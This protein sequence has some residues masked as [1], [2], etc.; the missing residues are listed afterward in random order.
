MSLHKSLSLMLSAI[1]SQALASGPSP[2]P[3]RASLPTTPSGPAP[4]RANL[5]ARQAQEQGLLTS[6]TSGHTSTTSLSS[7]ALLSSLESKLRQKTDLVGS[8][9]YKLTWKRRVTPAGRWIPALRGTARRTSAN[10][11][12]SQVSISDILK[13]WT[14]PPAHDTS[15][16]SKTQKAK[17][18]CACLTL[19]AQLAGWPTALTRDWKDSPG[20]APTGVNPDGSHRDR[21][22]NLS[23]KSQ[24]AG[25]GTPLSNHA[26]GSPEGFLERKRKSVERGNKMGIS[27]SDLN[28]QAQSYL[29][30]WPTA[31]QADGEKNVRT[32]E[33]SLS[34][35][36]RKGSPQDL[37]Q[38][39]QI[40]GWPTP[41]SMPLAKAG[42]SQPGNN[43]YIRR[44]E[45]LMGKEVKG[46]NLGQLLESLPSDQPVRLTATG[47][48]LTGSSAGMES[49]GQ[50]DPS[51]SRWLM[52]LPPEWDDCAPT[53]TLSSL[54]KL[55][56]SATALK[57]F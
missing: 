43:D 38:A 1:S 54:R 42:Q 50:L 36:E 31:R 32:L 37:A 11:S 24:L 53:E 6:G 10:G 25:W 57:K 33:G 51:H 34:E 12:T 27:M 45:A 16:R 52:G 19:D 29:T 26:N 21:T 14:T 15:G 47:Q 20:Q 9:L 3:A 55:K 46:H 35:I 28:M 56:A 8:T 17:H 18:G 13:G 49:G 30:G 2:S 41:M 4:A 23:S 7:A 44:T 48:M 40:T 39:T 5:S 22:D